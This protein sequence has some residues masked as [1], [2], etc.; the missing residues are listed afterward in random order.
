[1]KDSSI[2]CTIMRGG[3]SKGL[4]FLDS[5][6]P[7]NPQQRSECLLRAFGSPDVRQI[8]GLGGADP[9]TSKVAIIRSSN[10]PGVD[11]EYT[12]GQVS[13][14]EPFIDFSGNC[15]NIS[16]AVGPFAIHKHLVPAVEP[17]TTVR[18]FNTNTK[19]MII[20]EVPVQDGTVVSRGSY[21]IDGVPGT[22]AEI[23]LHFL[24]PAGALTGKLLP[25]GNGVDKIMMENGRTVDVSIV[26]AGN[27][28][29]F[30]RADQIDLRGDE[31]PQQIDSR[32]D[33][34]A[35]L[36]ELRAKI[37][38]RLGLCG[39]WR[40]AYQRYRSI[41]KIVFVSAPAAFRTLQGKNVEEENIDLMA[42][43]MSMGRLHKAFA[44]T[45]AIPT[46]AA[47]RVPGSVVHKLCRQCSSTVRI[48]HPSGIISVGVAMSEEKDGLCLREVIVGRT[49][50]KI[51]EGQVSL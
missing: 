13:I 26:D 25:T 43:V 2:P 3:T 23:K 28:A 35:V 32:A 12:F 1:M 31:L 41:P 46:A 4:F 36:E 17:V 16:S 50:R 21:R 22:G 6:L 20:S 48:G 11:V 14:T 45:A 42:R 9:L 40:E 44:V 24:D 8:D 7:T 18:I 47:S 38:E 49:A 39:N 19:K 15:G 33:V 10:M 5:D 27:P 37:S 34:L 29:G 51:M 30:V